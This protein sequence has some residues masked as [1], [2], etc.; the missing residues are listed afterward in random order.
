MQYIHYYKDS[1][2]IFTNYHVERYHKY[3]HYLPASKILSKLILHYSID[4]L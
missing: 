4:N 3:L 2:I 1:D